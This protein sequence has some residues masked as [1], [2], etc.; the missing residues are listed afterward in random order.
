M[1]GTTEPILAII[2]HPI[3]GNPTQFALES[4]FATAQMDCRVLSID[5]AQDKVA[6]AIAGM[7]AMGFQGVWV[8][9]A[10]QAAVAKSLD[11]ASIEDSS[12][13][14]A[15]PILLDFLTRSALPQS[16]SAWSPH[17]LKTQV[18]AKLA[19]NAIQKRNRGCA[20]LWWVDAAASF[21]QPNLV[22]EKKVLL[23]QMHQ[24]KQAAWVDWTVDQVEIVD[25]PSQIEQGDDDEDHVIVFARTPELPL[26]WRMP[27]QS[28]TIDLNENWDASH[29]ARW[30]RIKSSSTGVCIRSADVHAA[31]LSQL[32]TLLFGLHVDNEVFLEAIDEYLAV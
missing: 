16:D 26:K 20:K 6:A 12:E 25:V 3:A 13:E 24:V 31:C 28:V 2:G 7:D 22:L 15:T 5:L 11:N 9:P 4:G 23:D 18:W 17:A 1:D 21:S 29:L 19:S 10:C 30:D 14:P 27:N 32:T 8:T